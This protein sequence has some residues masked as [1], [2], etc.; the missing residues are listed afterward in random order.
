MGCIEHCKE[1]MPSVGDERLCLA[2][3]LVHAHHS[4]IQNVEGVALPR[5]GDVRN[6]EH[7]CWSIIPLAPTRENTGSMNHSNIVSGC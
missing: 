2:Q 5:F 6:V 1:G 4:V 3:C 7:N